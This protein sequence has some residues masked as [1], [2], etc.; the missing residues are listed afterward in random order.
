MRNRSVVVIDDDFAM[1][2]LIK[3]WLDDL[4]CE[5]RT[6]SRGKE[7]MHY[8]TEHNNV[9]LVITDIFMPEMDGIE[10]VST[11]RRFNNDIR[12]I[13]MSS[14]GEIEYNNVTNIAVKLGADAALNKPFTNDDLIKLYKGFLISS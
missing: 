9:D 14:G 1:Q 5:V 10:V 3:I 2:K 13:A 6:F 7:A 11:L 4:D 8:I 12:I